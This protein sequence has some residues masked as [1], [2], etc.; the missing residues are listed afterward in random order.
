MV[1]IELHIEALVLHGFDPLEKDRI[2]SAVRD[3]LAR[4]VLEQKETMVSMQGIRR[5][6]IDAGAFA[7]RENAKPGSIGVCIGQKVF[8]AMTRNR[9]TGVIQDRG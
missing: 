3:E 9:E 2:G 1:T 6:R 5:S 7:V 4:Q 8:A